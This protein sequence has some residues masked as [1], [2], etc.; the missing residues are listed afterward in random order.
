MPQD[1]VDNLKAFQLARADHRFC[2]RVVLLCA[3]FPVVVRW[4]IAPGTMHSLSQR[5][6]QTVRLRPD[7][8][9]GNT[10]FVAAVTSQQT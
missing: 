5:C 7:E 4:E 8:S 3:D 6:T 10:D 1:L 2:G 9:S